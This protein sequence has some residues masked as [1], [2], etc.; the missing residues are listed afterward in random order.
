MQHLACQ[1]SDKVPDIS[2][3]L[4]VQEDDAHSQEQSFAA[5][6]LS[7]VGGRPESDAEAGGV[8]RRALQLARGAGYLQA[9]A[10]VA[11]F[12]DSMSLCMSQGF[13]MCVQ[14]IKSRCR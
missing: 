6:L 3:G 9:Q 1:M 12:L 10:Q 5:V 2:Q 4:G 14:T 8:L 13:E 7:A 11:S